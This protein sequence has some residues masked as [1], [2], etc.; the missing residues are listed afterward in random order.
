MV[1]SVQKIEY[2]L[3]K[4]PFPFN[5]ANLPR[6]DSWMTPGGGAYNTLWTL[7]YRHPSS[8]TQFLVEEVNCRASIPWCQS[9]KHRL[10]WSF[11]SVEGASVWMIAYSK[12]S[13][14]TQLKQRMSSVPLLLIWP[15]LATQN[16]TSIPYRTDLK[17]KIHDEICNTTTTALFSVTFFPPSSLF[18]WLL[19]FSRLRP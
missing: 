12:Y 10:V 8:Y 13:V 5:N 14:V 15:R 11:C 4:S 7:R 16:T 1:T 19:R 17:W 18:L 9:G 2:L 6:S 3:A